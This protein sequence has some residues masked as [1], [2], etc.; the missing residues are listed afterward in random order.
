MM[1]EPCAPFP[2][3]QGPIE[4]NQWVAALEEPVKRVPLWLTIDV[5]VIV[6]S[7]III[8]IWV[9]IGFIASSP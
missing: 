4:L 9:L 2:C 6:I 8:E 7:A 5:A 3:P 1:A